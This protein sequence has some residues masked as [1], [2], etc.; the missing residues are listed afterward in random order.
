[1]KFREGLQVLTTVFMSTEDGMEVDTPVGTTAIVQNE[2]S[3]DEEL[4]CVTINGSLNYLPQN[5]FEL[6]PA[7]GWCHR[8]KTPVYPTTVDGYS[9]YCPELDEDLYAFEWTAYKTLEGST[10]VFDDVVNDDGH[11]WTQVCKEHVEHLENEPNAGGHL[12]AGGYGTCGVVGC[13]KESYFY[14]D[15]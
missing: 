5:V 1:M 15:F 9:A 8:T 6:S 14:L 11:E 13:E 4:L 3:N 2:P 12:N 10:L 7:I